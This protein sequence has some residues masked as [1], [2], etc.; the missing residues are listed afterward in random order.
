[1]VLDFMRAEVFRY[2]MVVGL[3][4]IIFVII[5][6]ADMSSSGHVDNRK[7]SILIFGKSLTKELDDTKLT[8]EKEYTI[9][10]SEQQK[11]FSLTVHYNDMN[12]YF[13]V[14]SVK[15]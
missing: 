4:K 14:N 5:F 8:A 6:G 3:L 2:L 1:M 10:L 9:Y 7:K 12:S 11:K 15:I 13:F